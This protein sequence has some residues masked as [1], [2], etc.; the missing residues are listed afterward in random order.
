MSLTTLFSDEQGW[1]ASG[2]LVYAAHEREGLEDTL[3]QAERLREIGR[4]S[5]RE[6]V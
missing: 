2:R 6:R 3:A 4:A 1:L 5:C